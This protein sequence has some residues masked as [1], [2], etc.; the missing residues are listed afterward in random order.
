[1]AQDG[2]VFGSVL[3]ESAEPVRELHRLRLGVGLLRRVLR[4]DG[5]K[6]IFHPFP[7]VER[8]RAVPLRRTVL[9]FLHGIELL[10]KSAS[11]AE[12]DRPRRALEQHANL[13]RNQVGAQEEDISA[14]APPIEL[15]PQLRFVCP[16]ESFKLT[17]N[18]QGVG[19]RLLVE[20]TETAFSQLHPQFSL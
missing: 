13:K 7:G 14:R 12:E 16:K 20:N 2:D 19:L 8:K 5:R 1:M 6:L 17:L 15:R 18:I 9:G 3:A 10:G 11:A 4:E